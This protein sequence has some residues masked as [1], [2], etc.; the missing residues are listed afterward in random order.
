MVFLPLGVRITPVAYSAHLRRATLFPPGDGLLFGEHALDGSH[1]AMTLAHGGTRLAWSWRKQDPFEVRGTWR[2]EASGE[3]GLR[4][5]LNLCLS[6]E[7]GET[8]RLAMARRRNGLDEQ[9]RRLAGESYAL[10]SARWE[11]ARLCPENDNADTGEALDQPDTEGFYGWGVL[12]P[13]LGLAAIT[14]VTPWSGWEIL[15]EGEDA[16]PS[17][18]HSR[19][20]LDRAAGC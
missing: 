17:G 12:M 7:G 10:F 13:M 14:D 19:S 18:H 5:W 3:W 8:V 11:G 6:A 9:A 15:N 1:I 4:F 2:T 20:L 16:L